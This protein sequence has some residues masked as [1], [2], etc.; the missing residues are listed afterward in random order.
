MTI[1]IVSAYDEYG[2]T[3]PI[4]GKAASIIARQRN[5]GITRDR[6]LQFVAMDGEQVV[7]GAW[8]AF[9]G[10]NYEFD[11]AV[12][13]RFE[14]Q[15]IGRQLTQAAI[16][17]RSEVT[18]G[19]GNDSTMLVPVTSWSMCRLL[20]K[21]GFILTDVPQKGFFTM[22]PKDECEPYQKPHPDLDLSDWLS[23]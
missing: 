18:E 14:R 2:E 19:Y 13:P 1:K 12:D 3:D 9:D 8:V 17:E 15:G 22:G 20:E 5:L 10:D 23:P 6:V 16:A 21:E 11:I 4:L 7:G